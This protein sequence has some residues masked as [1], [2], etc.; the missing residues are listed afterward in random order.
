MTLSDYFSAAGVYRGG[1]AEDGFWWSH[2]DKVQPLTD[3]YN[4]LMR[5]LHGGAGYIAPATPSGYGAGG[6]HGTLL[7][8][9]QYFQSVASH[10]EEGRLNGVVQQATPEQAA[11]RHAFDAKYSGFYQLSPEQVVF[12]GGEI[13]LKQAGPSIGE[14]VERPNE[15]RYDPDFGYITTI[16]ND[17]RAGNPGGFT[18]WPALG[19]MLA[20]FV[21][22]ALQ[23]LAAPVAVASEVAPYSVSVIEAVPL[24]SDAGFLPGSF[25]LGAS[26][27]GGTAAAGLDAAAL[28]WSTASLDGPLVS[29]AKTAAAIQSI[30]DAARAALAVVG[31]AGSVKALDAKPAP[32]AARLELPAASDAGVPAAS[33][34][35]L[36]LGVAAAVG[37]IWLAVKG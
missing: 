5:R 13:F 35:A 7:S 31:L 25:E 21:V 9:D 29:A 20:P 30:G 8:L 26:S 32:G 3:E 11:A 17:A 23:S 10:D 22:G 36:G 33:W 28:E 4:S 2:P 37:L 15:V 18:G 12:R 6:T 14:Y 24:A 34:I 1:N 16:G 19:L 27:Y